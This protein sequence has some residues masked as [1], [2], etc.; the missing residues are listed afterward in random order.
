VSG[1][2]IT[3]S[4]DVWVA[5]LYSNRI[6]LRDGTSGA[7]IRS[8]ECSTPWG[9]LHLLRGGSLAVGCYSN[10][11]VVLFDANGTQRWSSRG[12]GFNY[13]LGAAG[14]DNELFVCDY[15]NNRIQVLSITDGRFVRQFGGTGQMY[16]PSGIAY[17]ANARV[18]L[19][20]EKEK[21]SVWSLNGRCLH[22]CGEHEH[23]NNPSITLSPDGTI[24]MTS[25]SHE[26]VIM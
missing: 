18:L 1:L 19:V 14:V 8:I 7:L 6:Q 21:L 2:A 20:L 12:N 10:H 13:V 4:G 9:L 15:R 11:T 17:D 5:L 22:K 25:D 24:Y 3:S 16:Y 23:Y 26:I